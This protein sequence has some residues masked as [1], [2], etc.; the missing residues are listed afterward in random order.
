MFSH[1]NP[2]AHNETEIQKI[3]IV[4]V[5]SKDFYLP[6]TDIQPI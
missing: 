5:S 3:I 6:N 1:E 2:L 4:K